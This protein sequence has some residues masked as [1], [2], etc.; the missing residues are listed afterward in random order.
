MKRTILCVL[1]IPIVLISGCSVF[2]YLDGS[3]DE[4]V[5]QFSKTRK[6]LRQE[7]AA[8]Q[9]DKKSLQTT[10]NEKQGELARLDTKEKEHLKAIGE[11]QSRIENLEKE[12]VVL[13]EENRKLKSAAV[14]KE[15]TL[16]EKQAREI[17]QAQFIIGD[18]TSGGSKSNVWQ[19]TA[20]LLVAPE[21]A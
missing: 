9:S 11:G 15:E 7:L 1:M 13:E 10:L 18:P 17:L 3:S 21:L 16:L 14:A 20:D 6:D 2:R 8:L 12:K 19:G 4:E 5:S